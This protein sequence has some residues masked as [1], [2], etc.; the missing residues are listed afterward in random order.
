MYAYVSALPSDVPIHMQM[1]EMDNQIQDCMLFA[2][3][4]LI[5]CR[6]ITLKISAHVD[7]GTS[8]TVKHA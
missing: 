2:K 6:V 4:I 1:D 3:N 7:I 5:F 8:E